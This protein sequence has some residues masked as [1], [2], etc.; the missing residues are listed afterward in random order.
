MKINI[1]TLI[2]ASVFM[3]GCSAAKNET[4]APKTDKEISLTE[5]WIL[6][7]FNEPESIIPDGA[8]G[9]FVSNVNG[10]G[11][12]KDGNGYISRISS[13]GKMLDRQWADGL[14]APKGMALWEGTLYV[15]DIDRLVM[16]DSKSGDIKNS[17]SVPEAVFFNDV[18]ASAKG[19]FVSD[20]GKALIRRLQG[21]TLPIWLEDEHLNRING[22]LPQSDGMLVT[23]MAKGDLLSIDWKDKS[24]TGLAT[25]MVN[26]DGLGVRPDGSFLVSSYPGQIWH[27]QTGQT[28]RKLLDTSG[29][30]GIR[31]N[32]SLFEDE[33]VLSP[34]WQP[35]T[36]REYLI[37]E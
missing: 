36:V 32:D 21:E 29:E 34:N 18:A 5:G 7:G 27:A 12:G 28:P 2:S 20:S 16:I 25:G 13:D 3:A 11:R 26:A 9:Y 10:E 19:V 17:V 1:I 37:V 24:I 35:G 30:A 33:R 8:G 4:A 31:H 22:L 14:D 15:T 23:T 6:S